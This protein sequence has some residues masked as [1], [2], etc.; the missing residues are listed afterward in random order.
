M[1]AGCPQKASYLAPQRGG[2][3]DQ[4]LGGLST[5]TSTVRSTKSWCFGIC[6]AST[7]LHTEEFLVN[8][9]RVVSL[10]PSANGFS[11]RDIA[12]TA[13]YESDGVLWGLGESGSYKLEA[14]VWL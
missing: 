3:E 12:P 7:V 1:L 4:R 10:R 8:S 13:K 11:C 14:P 5:T 9:T 2:Q 6:T